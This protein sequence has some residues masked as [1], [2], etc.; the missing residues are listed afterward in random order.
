MVSTVSS[1]FQN[2]EN[3]WMVTHN[4]SMCCHWQNHRRFWR[5]IANLI[6]IKRTNQQKHE[7]QGLL[8]NVIYFLALIKSLCGKTHYLHYKYIESPIS[9]PFPLVCVFV[10]KIFSKKCGNSGR[11]LYFRF[12]PFSR[13]SFFLSLHLFKRWKSQPQGMHNLFSPIFERRPSSSF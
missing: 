5:K 1:M 12:I 9:L 7:G 3:Y 6:K 11:S 13:S 10:C 8:Y 2:C 4:R